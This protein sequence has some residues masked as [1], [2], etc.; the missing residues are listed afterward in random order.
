MTAMAKNTMKTGYHTGNSIMTDRVT[1]IIKRIKRNPELARAVCDKIGHTDPKR[2]QDILD[3]ANLTVSLQEACAILHLSSKTVGNLLR[4][5]QIKGVL[6]GGKGGRW[7]IPKPALE[8]FL[9]L[10]G[11]GQ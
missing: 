1:D 6:I 8:Q 3:L 7:L 11:A 2:E 5:G 4:E 9:K 10:D